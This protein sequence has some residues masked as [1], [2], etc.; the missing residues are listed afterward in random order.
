MKKEYRSF[1][2]ARKFV[3]RLKLSTQKDWQEYCNSGNKPDDIPKSPYTVWKNKGWI[4]SGDF[5]GTGRVATYNIVYQSFKD[6]KK[7]A[8]SLNLKSRKEWV[9]YTKSGKKPDDIPTNVSQ[10]YKKEWEGWGDFLGTGSVAPNDRKFCSFK[11]A[12]KFVRK[13]KFKNRDDWKKYCRSGNKPDNIPVA[14]DSTYK[15]QWTSWGDFSGTGR[16][17]TQNRIYQSFKESRSFVQKLN[18]KYRD[19]F[20]KF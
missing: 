20:K 16:V 6:A 5:F 14:P 1:D 7:L 12:K 4:S 3:R 17:A 10:S 2:D 11:D 8:Q 15:K 18:L 13:L 19:E 9:E